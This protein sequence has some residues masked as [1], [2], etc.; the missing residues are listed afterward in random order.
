MAADDEAPDARECTL[1]ALEKYI[2]DSIEAG[3]D[4]LD[5][6]YVRRCVRAIESAAVNETHAQCLAHRLRG[7]LYIVYDVEDD[8]F[9]LEALRRSADMALDILRLFPLRYLDCIRDA[10]HAMSVAPIPPDQVEPFFEKAAQLLR[11]QGLTRFYSDEACLLNDVVRYGKA[12]VLSLLLELGLDPNYSH[13]DPT[14]AHH[15]ISPIW[16][17]VTRNKTAMLELLLKHGADPDAGLRS[18]IADGTSPPDDTPVMQ[19]YL[20]CKAMPPF[21]PIAAKLLFDYG[22]SLWTVDSTGDIMMDVVTAFSEGLGKPVPGRNP[23][24]RFLDDP[25]IVEA[26]RELRAILADAI[27][28]RM[29]LALLS[30]LK[31]QSMRALERHRPDELERIPPMMLKLDRLWRLDNP[32]ACDLSRL[33]DLAA[34]LP[35]VIGTYEA[36]QA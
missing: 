23:L 10:V 32:L 17:A 27:E 36:G 15:F 5:E 4:C 1:P 6:G 2:I 9:F 33:R 11:S 24:H 14:I 34:R 29:R 16:P 35:V 28:R 8:N 21:A 7:S 19:V 31:S 12:R 3:R 18:S 22:A 20:C 30:P 26:C 13:T 25:E